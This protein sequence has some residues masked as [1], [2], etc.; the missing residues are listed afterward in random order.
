[1]VGPTWTRVHFA[2]GSDCLPALFQGTI[3]SLPPTLCLLCCSRAH[4]RCL[5]SDDPGLYQ[6]VVFLL[7]ICLC[8]PGGYTFDHTYIHL[9]GSLYPMMDYILRVYYGLS[10]P[11]LLMFH[12]I[13][14]DSFTIGCCTGFAVL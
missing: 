11:C 2:L 3:S 7:L 14:Y 6:Y 12:G 13:P 10:I 1:M 8:G 9:H 4:V 5:M